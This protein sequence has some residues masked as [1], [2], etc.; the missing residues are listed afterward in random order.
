[1]PFFNN[2]IREYGGEPFHTGTGSYDAV[3]LLAHAVTDSQSFNADKIVTTLEKINASN[4]LIGA[5]GNLSFTKS[6][7]VLKGYP[8]GYG[9][10]CQY[11]YIDG[12]K[13]V[14]PSDLVY[15]K[16]IATD[17]IR[18]PYWGVNGLLTEPPDPPDG[19]TIYSTADIPEDIDGEF[20]LTWAESEDADNYS[21][22]MS[23]IPMTYISK[24]FDLLAYQTATSPFTISL[25]SKGEYYFRV[26]AYNKTG[27]T[28]SNPVHVKVPGPGDFI[29]EATD[30]GEPDRD[31]NFNLI[32]TN[33]D[34]VVNYSVYQYR[35]EIT[36]ING[37]LIIL[38]NQSINQ[39]TAR[40]L[41]V[42][43]LS[44]GKYYFVVV[45]HNEMGYTLSNNVY[46]VVRLPIDIITLSIII[47]GSVAGVASI[48]LIRKYLKREKKIK[49]EPKDKHK[50]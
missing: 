9:L 13:V 34:R 41:P 31:G 5:G 24:K 42:T 2:F 30:A 32:W 7:D 20:N 49:I 1:M 28:M 39:T 19:F 11:K 6:H 23:N 25:K 27:E 33:S 38:A 8:H 26:V 15:P 45:A 3:Y 43:E 47:I 17:S 14:I 18:L 16:F 50:K 21:I 10:L 22:Y 46:V 12:T 44:D 29:L 40:S 36:S 48:V 37:S 4:P 35:S